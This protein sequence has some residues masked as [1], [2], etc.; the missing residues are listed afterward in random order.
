MNEKWNAHVHVN[1]G[2]SSRTIRWDFGFLNV[3]LAFPLQSCEFCGRR[4]LEILF[5]LS[6]L[7][8]GQLISTL[9][10]LIAPK[11]VVTRVERDLDSESWR[12]VNWVSSWN[13]VVNWGTDSK[14]GNILSSCS[15]H[16]LLYSPFRDP[17]RSCRP[18]RPWNETWTMMMSANVETMKFKFSPRKQANSKKIG[19]SKRITFW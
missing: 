6:D 18:W 17:I 14:P 8:V 3:S 7:D 16:R 5:E 12:H 1:D 2:P 4:M 15:L 10:V 9:L 11:D 19:F 13:H